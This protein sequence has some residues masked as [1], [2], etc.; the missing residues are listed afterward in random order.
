MRRIVLEPTLHRLGVECPVCDSRS[1]WDLG[2]AMALTTPCWRCGFRLI[3][4]THV[5]EARDW[6]AP[7]D[8]G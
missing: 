5:G 1:W 4:L 8:G 7:P 2:E 6:D 3:A